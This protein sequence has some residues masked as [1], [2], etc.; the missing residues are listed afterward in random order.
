MEVSKCWNIVEFPKI[1]FKMKNCKTFYGVQTMSRLKEI[2]QP[3]SAP[4]PL[5]TPP[6]CKI[7]LLFGTKVF[8]PRYTEQSFA[9][10]MVQECIF[11]ASEICLLENWQIHKGFLLCCGGILFSMSSELRFV[12]WLSIFERLCIV[13][14]VIFV[15]S[16]CWFWYFLLENLKFK[17]KLWCPLERLDEYKKVVCPK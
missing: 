10:K 13:K 4:H 17:K 1:S 11:W 8:L 3:P 15:T 5:P 12:K 16:V 6:S 9:S 14:W 2:I 7:L